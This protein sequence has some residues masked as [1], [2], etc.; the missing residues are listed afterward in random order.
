MNGHGHIVPNKDGSKARC[1]GPA[2]CSECA[3]ELIEEHAAAWMRVG[4]ADPQLVLDPALNIYLERAR[5]ATRRLVDL[6]RDFRRPTQ[7]PDAD[8]LNAAPALVGKKAVVLY[9]D[10]ERDRDELVALIREA[11]PNMRAVNL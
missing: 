1:G 9:F 6:L 3:R 8:A 7:R 11:K 5:Q 4:S 2:L 10:T